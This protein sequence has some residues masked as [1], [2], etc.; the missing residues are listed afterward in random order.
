MFSSDCDGV[1]TTYSW[2]SSVAVTEG[3]QVVRGEVIG[4]TGQ[5]HPE[6]PQP[7]LHLGA[8]VGST[9]IDPILL[10]E[11]GSVTGL[12]HLAPL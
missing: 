6:I 12:I 1:R 8:R 7:H 3:Q 9:Y 4:A 5:G 2:V 11:R 10:L